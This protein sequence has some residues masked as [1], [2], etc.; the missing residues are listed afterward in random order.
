MSF[1]YLEMVF[2]C[3]PDFLVIPAKAL[4]MPVEVG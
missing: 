1:S 2:M 4:P 3:T